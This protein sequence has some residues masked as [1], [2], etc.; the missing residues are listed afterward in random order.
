[1]NLTDTTV[2]A[3]IASTASE[4]L[5]A[6]I[7]DQGGSLDAIRATIEAHRSWPRFCELARA[8]DVPSDF[9]GTPALSGAITGWARQTS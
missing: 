6:A 2:I 5:I 4:A 7:V 8:G 3:S 1:M 9:T